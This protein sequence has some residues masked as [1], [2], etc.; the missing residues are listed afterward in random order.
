MGALW[1]MITRYKWWALIILAAV[2]VGSQLTYD[3]YQSKNKPAIA[4]KVITVERSDI[5]STIAATGTITPV[6]LVNVSSKITGLIREVKVNENDRVKAGQILILLD[7]THLKAL[8][9]QARARLANAEANYVRMGKLADMGAV[10]HQQLDAARMDYHV[11]QAA[12]DDAVSQF[13][14]TVIKAP[15]DG[16][17]IGKPIPAGQT[18]SPGISTPMILLTIADMSKMQI[19][20]QIDETD[21]GKTAVGQKVT[22]TVDAYPGKTFTGVVANISQK[23]VIQQN[24]VYYPVIIDVDSPEGLLRPTMTARISILAGE[25]KGVLT[26]PLAA[27][28][29]AKGQRYVVQVNGDKT[30]NITVAT[31]LSTEDRIEIVSGLREGDRILL[32]QSR[33]QGAAPGGSP[34]QRFMG[35]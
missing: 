24:V 20:A 30:Q 28:K 10:S 14:D 15:I 26:V 32:P 27:V 34:L 17:V 2:A 12:Y 8:V 4:G 23:A 9:S 11:A 3:Y 5:T 7:D 6:N 22:F 19:E 13:N 1:R 33:Q 29:E 21:I 31:G 35:R 18:V 16:T 25:R